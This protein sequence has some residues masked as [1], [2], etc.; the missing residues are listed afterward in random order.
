MSPKPRAWNSLAASSGVPLAFSRM[1]SGVGRSRLADEAGAFRQ[2]TEADKA[3]RFDDALFIDGLQRLLDR[4]VL[5]ERDRE[6]G[7]VLG[8]GF[9]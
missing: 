5:E 9:R 6:V 7:G 1:S 3:Q 4:G 8:L 2:L